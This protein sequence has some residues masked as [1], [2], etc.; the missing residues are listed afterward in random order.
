LFGAGCD[1][2][3]KDTAPHRLSRHDVNTARGAPLAFLIAGAYNFRTFG[4][5]ADVDFRKQNKSG[6]GLGGALSSG[7]DRACPGS[8]RDLFKLARRLP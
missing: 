4:E 3:D 2:G 7:A 8:R 6:I 1:D 5:G